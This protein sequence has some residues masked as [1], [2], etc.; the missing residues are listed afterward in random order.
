MDE[1]FTIPTTWLK[2]GL[3][4]EFYEAAD[5]SGEPIEA[6]DG[7]GSDFWWHIAWTP[8]QI[9]PM[10]MRW[11]GSLTVPVDGSYKIALNHVGKVKLFLDGKVHPGK[12]L[13]R[14]PARR[15]CSPGV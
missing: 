3:H 2:G 15:I 10:A 9:K 6:R 14:N 11:T 13:P 8:L 12:R 5:F 7:F 4:G 1:P